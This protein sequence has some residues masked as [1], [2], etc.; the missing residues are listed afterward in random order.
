L[1]MNEAMASGLPIFA[2]DKCGGAIDL[3]TPDTGLI[4]ESDN[5]TELYKAML[6]YIDNRSICVSN[7][8][9]AQAYIQYF[10]YTRTINSLQ[11]LINQF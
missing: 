1:A 7:G 9:S 5:Q 2:S 6:F 11:F 10:N 3:I 4:F 8:L